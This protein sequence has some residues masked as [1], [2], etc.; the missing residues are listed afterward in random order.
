MKNA[1]VLVICGGL[2]L[3]LI[4]DLAAPLEE[5]GERA[6]REHSGELTAVGSCAPSVSDVEYAKV[7]LQI[8]SDGADQ[9]R[10][11]LEF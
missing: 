2:A 3:S 1:N 11:R 6:R 7:D 5:M 10:V 8:G 4:L 9:S